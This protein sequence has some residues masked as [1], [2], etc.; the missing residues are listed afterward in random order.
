L[1]ELVGHPIKVSFADDGEGFGNLGIRE[2]EASG[3]VHGGVVPSSAS[4]QPILS[5]AIHF[6]EARDEGDVTD[7]FSIQ[8][9][10]FILKC[11]VMNVPFKYRGLL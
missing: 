10:A 11:E 8:G 5:L 2:G 1:I 7:A 6:S 9:Y 4:S 3:F